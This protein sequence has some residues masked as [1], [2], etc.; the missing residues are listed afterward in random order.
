[1]LLTGTEVSR[2][3]QENIERKI[4]FCKENNVVPALAVVRAGNKPEDLSYER[5]VLK[6]CE[7]L[8]IAVR[9]FTFP[10]TVSTEELIA[11]IE[12]INR[13][14]ALHGVLMFCPLP[15]KTVD[16][17]RVRNALLPEKD[18]D[19]LTPLSAYGIF[20]GKNIG[21]P[22]CT[23]EACRRVLEYYGISCE[24]KKV[25]VVGRSMVVGRPL[26]MMLLKQNATVTICHTKTKNLREECLAADIVVATAG[27]RHLL[28]G[29]CFRKGQVVL[30]VGINPDG[31]NGIC[32]DVVTEEA[33]KVADA[34]TP[35]PGGVGNVTT[36]VLLDHLTE[37]ALKKTGR[38]MKDCL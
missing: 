6:R 30:Y 8:D 28:D 15:K 21:Y 29:S 4:A 10:E 38:Q 27:R 37:A 14:D 13:D 35:V 5:S 25:T 7:K 20:A 11:A 33:L 24:G 23:P 36:S 22:P 34:V 17:E 1:M 2:H 16:E 19:G 26:S 32:G 12:E 3:I 31:E 9:Q 18:L